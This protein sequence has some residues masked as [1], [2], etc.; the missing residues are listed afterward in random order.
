MS[1]Q[2][3]F[4]EAYVLRTKVQETSASD[5]SSDRFLNLD[6]SPNFD[7][8]SDGSC[9]ICCGICRYNFMYGDV[10]DDLTIDDGIGGQEFSRQVGVDNQ[11]MYLNSIK[12]IHDDTICFLNLK[13]NTKENK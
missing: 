8:C 12:D 5:F 3:V 1:L 7:L 4:K 2:S 13:L 10:V 9:E 6:L 11:E